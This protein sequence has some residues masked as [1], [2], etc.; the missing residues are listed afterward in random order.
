M[1]ENLADA[2]KNVIQDEEKRRSEIAK[3]KK[4][5]RQF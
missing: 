5:I 1:T 2:D 3:H 4:T